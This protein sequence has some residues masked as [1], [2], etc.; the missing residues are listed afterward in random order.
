[1]MAAGVVDT[2]I[3]GASFGVMDRPGI[4][5][6]TDAKLAS[7]GS[8]EK[9]AGRIRAG[10]QGPVAA[11]AIS[12]APLFSR[13]QLF[14]GASTNTSQFVFT[15]NES[16]VPAIGARSGSPSNTT[17]L[18]G[19]VLAKMRGGS[20]LR[21]TGGGCCARWSRLS[22]TVASGTRLGPTRASSALI[23]SS[24]CAALAGSSVGNCADMSRGAVRITTRS[25]KSTCVSNATLIVP[26]NG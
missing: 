4:C 23:R 22:T 15:A 13:Y 19:L 21:V 26:A 2:K 1:M 7:L 16:E 18:A 10:T 17:R 20:L 11:G 8:A 12:Q 14:V 3:V 5:F 6:F 25:K 9:D 24:T